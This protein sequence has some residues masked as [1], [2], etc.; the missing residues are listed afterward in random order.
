[1]VLFLYL[2]FFLLV[3]KFKSFFVLFL[4]KQPIKLVI[5]EKLAKVY[6]HDKKNELL[7]FLQY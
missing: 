6:N 4:L 2:G 7:F 1:M 5:I 3:L